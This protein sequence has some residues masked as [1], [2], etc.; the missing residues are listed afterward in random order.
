MRTAELFRFCVGRTFL[1]TGFN[2]YGFVELQVSDDLA[3]KKKFGL[4]W[5]WMEPGFIALVTKTKRK[6]TRPTNGFGWKEDFCESEA[7][8]K[9]IEKKAQTIGGKR[10]KS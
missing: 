4:N 2:R 3:V 10:S 7:A 8:A 5:I 9:R 1:V 6:V